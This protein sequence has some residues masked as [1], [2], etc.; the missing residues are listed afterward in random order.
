MKALLLEKAMLTVECGS[1]V[2]ISESQFKALG[3]KAVAYKDEAKEVEP[4]EKEEKPKR[5]A[6]SKK[7]SRKKKE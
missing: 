4:E 6:T 2:E 1:I 7:T 3:K 5:A